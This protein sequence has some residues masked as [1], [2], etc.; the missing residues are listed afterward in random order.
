[1]SSQQST[2]LRAADIHAVV[3]WPTVLLQ[4]GIDPAFLRPRKQGP[5]PACNGT[6]RYSFDNRKGRGDFICR[7]CGAG[8][9]FELLRRVH[10]WSFSDARRRVIEA[11]GLSSD[12]G[13]NGAPLRIQQSIHAAESLSLSVP[14]ARVRRLLASSCDLPD[15]PYV[16]AYLSAREVWPV[17]AGCAL[18]AHVSMEYWDDGQ[19]VGRFAG[20]V[21][22]I[23]DISG[24][25]VTAHVTYLNAGS[26]LRSHEPRKIL[27]KMVGR[28]GCAVRLM[29]AS[30]TLGIAEG[31]ETAL[32]AALIDRVPVWAALNTALLVRFEP[33]AC[34]TTLRI[35]ADRDEPG[36]LA[37]GQLMQ[38]LQGRVRLELRTPSP[39]HKDFNDQL[40]A[41]E[42]S[43]A[44]DV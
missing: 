25:L 2:Q 5:C 4:L 6:D 9:G 20:L 42:R 15:C 33:P 17:P 16:V 28:V 19:S 22:P 31:I 29:P 36:L 26:K 34:V 11:A 1:M 35:Y 38:R 3:N 24:D 13:G 23:V 14:T 37:A 10:G 7:Q 32:S 39:P 8:D 30:E 27:S 12:I 18:R 44:S 40:R 41:G 43:E 21:A